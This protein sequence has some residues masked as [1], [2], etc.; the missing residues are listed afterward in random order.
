MGEVICTL[1][2]P[3]SQRRDLVLPDH[4]PVDQLVN[5]L[6]KALGLERSREI[7]YELHQ[8]DGDA[9]RRIPG[10]RTLQQ[11]FVLN[12]SCLHLVQVHEDPEHTAF[13]VTDGGHQIRLRQSTLIGRLTPKVHIDVDLTPMDAAKVVSRRHAAITRV[14]SHYLIKDLGSRNGTFIKDIRLKKDESRVL[15]P[16]DVICFGSLEKGVKLCFKGP[17]DRNCPLSGEGG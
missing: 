2:Y 17:L 7:Y 14:A 11:A 6:A 15:H 12:G 9:L 1:V 10:A 8:P 13:L 4:I 3:G 16:G 5:S